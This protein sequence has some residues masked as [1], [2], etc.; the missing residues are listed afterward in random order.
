[1]DGDLWKETPDLDTHPFELLSDETRQ[2][3]LGKT[4]ASMEALEGST[5]TELR[6]LCGVD[7]PGRFRYHVDKL[8]GTLLTHDGEQYRI[9]Y[10]TAGRAIA[11][12][13]C[14]PEQRTLPRSRS[15]LTEH[16]CPYCDRRVGARH[17]EVELLIL[18]CPEHSV[19]FSQPFPPYLDSEE[20][21]AWVEYAVQQ[22]H[23]DVERLDSGRC[24]W[25]Q[26]SVESIL[27]RG[28]FTYDPTIE[29]P[30]DRAPLWTRYICEECAYEFWYPAAT[31][32]TVDH[33]VRAFFSCRGIDVRTRPFPNRYV[34]TIDVVEEGEDERVAD[35]RLAYVIDGDELA[36]HMNVTTDVTRVVDR[37]E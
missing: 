16:D 17:T 20:S 29:P 37:T 6:R 2:E 32:A 35:A 13:S 4:A 3:I 27:R 30:D 7:D 10:G 9:R 33:E 24:P 25:C 18:E 31:K 19:V 26:G 1:M 15:V 11:L 22:M 8:L 36:L 5:F 14:D 34:E 12:G 28:R 21:A 23:H